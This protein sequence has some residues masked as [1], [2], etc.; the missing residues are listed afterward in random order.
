MVNVMA[1]TFA[2]NTQRDN[3]TVIPP[4]MRFFSVLFSLVLIL[5]VSNT[6]KSFGQASAGASIAATIVTPMTVEKESD[7]EFEHVSIGA[8]SNRTS[9]QSCRSKTTPKGGIVAGKVVEAAFNITG[10]ADYAYSISVP[11]FLTVTTNTHVFTLETAA[12]SASGGHTLSSQG[13]DS[14]AI[15]GVLL[16]RASGLIASNIEIPNGLPVTIN[17]N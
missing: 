8:V 11:P 13:K 12:R 5:I 4:S 16:R 6:T 17:N 10:N 9:S 7:L 3:T 1:S 15:H 2:M 14:V